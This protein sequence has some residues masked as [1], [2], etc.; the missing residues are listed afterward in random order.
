MNLKQAARRLGIHYQ[1]AYRY[2]RSGQLAS[3]R[4]GRGYSISE[5]AVETFLARHEALHDV[6]PG[7]ASEPSDRGG[8]EAIDDAMAALD[9]TI[10]DARG[11]RDVVAEALSLAIG[12]L[13]V[14]RSVGK[15]ADD[16]PIAVHHRDAR[17]RALATTLVEN[18]RDDDLMFYERSALSSGET[19]NLHH[20]AREVSIAATPPRL[21]QHLDQTAGHSVLC[22]PAMWEDEVVA[23]LTLKR[24]RPGR[25]YGED[26]VAMAEQLAAVVAAASHRAEATLDG[27][28]R[29][30]ELMDAIATHGVEAVESHHET[31]GDG[32]AVVSDASGQIVWADESVETLAGIPSSSLVGR[33]LDELPLVEE[34]PLIDRLRRGALMYAD[35]ARTVVTR[36][37]TVKQVMTHFGAVRAEN[38]ELIALVMVAHELAQPT[39]PQSHGS[40][41]PSSAP[42]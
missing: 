13:A 33:M 5:A 25:P 17:Q 15:R 36:T 14:V 34:R 18:H 3:V 42:A 40:R 37:N 21:L 7:A 20:V 38:G 8:N 1:T 41:T 31:A 19:V 29:R 24:D 10:I 6:H 16:A 23:L 11:V 39:V 35:C 26:E 2:V 12:D 28:R 30:E 4:V 27:W 32:T 22:V 9:A